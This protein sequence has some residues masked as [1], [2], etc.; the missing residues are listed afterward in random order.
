MPDKHEI[1]A[2]NLTSKDVKDEAVRTAK[3][4]ARTTI[5][6]TL[7]SLATGFLRDAIKAGIGK[8][9]KPK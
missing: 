4:V 8:I 2:N 3:S 5:T 7:A 9:G 1:E 6:W